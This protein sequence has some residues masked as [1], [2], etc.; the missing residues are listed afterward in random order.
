MTVALGVGASL[1]TRPSS[2]VKAAPHTI[3]AVRHP[4][5]PD[6]PDVYLIL[7]NKCAGCHHSASEKRS[8]FSN[9]DALL[10][11]LDEDGRR[12]VYPG[13]PSES[14][15]WQYVAWNA[16]ARRDSPH[17]SSPMMP[18]DKS[19]WLSA[20]QLKIVERW[21]R[22][23]ALQYKL[24]ET[25]DIR[26]LMEID[27]PSARQCQAC[28]PNQYAEWARSMHHYAPRSPIFEAFNQTLQERTSGTIGTFCSRC[29]MPLGTDLG[30]NG[31][32]LNVHRSQ[33]SQEGVTCVVCHRRKDAS[34]KNN[35]RLHVEP[36]GLFETC[37]Y[38]PFEDSAAPHPAKGNRFIKSSAFC[39]TC[40]DVTSPDGVRLEEAFSEWQN[41]PAA[42]R[43]QTCQSCH[44]GPVQGIPIPDNHRPLGRAAV[45]AGIDPERLPLRHLTDHTFAGPDYSLLPDTE[46]PYRLDWMYEKD[47]RDV[48][49]LTPFQ[50]KTLRDL[51]RKNRQAL[52]LASQ[53]RYELLRNA[54]YVK[55]RAP[56]AACP[57]GHVKIR[58]D[59]TSKTAGHSFPTGFTAERQA[60]VQVT[61]LDPRG[62]VVFSS[63]DLDQNGD[64]RDEHSHDVESGKIPRDK[65]L[66]N[67][68]NKFIALTAIGT[69]RSPVLSVNRHLAPLNVVRPARGISASFG[70]PETFRISKGSLPPLATIGQTY[71]VKLPNVAGDYVVDVRLNFRHL[72]PVLLDH[73]GTPHLKHLLEIVVID[74]HRSVI[75]VA[76]G[77]RIREP[78]DIEANGL[79]APMTETT[80]APPPLP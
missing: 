22:N 8:D 28:H 67:F 15:L 57:G 24:P 58:A 66:L 74:Q 11:A 72:P 23:G 55:V 37:M 77:S 17:P 64:L 30:E 1:A 26:P 3:S 21:I 9:Y 4:Y 2:P 75:H 13:R 7:M 5:D 47:Y 6:W 40:H 43:G 38:G 42:K 16:E 53:K 14:V 76:D 79:N 54:A 10:S 32:R 44:M 29:H 20:G 60:W 68:Q 31:M 51:R 65:H 73:I 70:R 48:R 27:F 46:F 63:G 19:E 49:N 36:G 62:H 25:C 39:G 41:S 61:V 80:F 12:A 35:G 34:Y 78:I 18:A 59:V 52:D 45:V 69:E 33:L 56:R 50:Q 71:P